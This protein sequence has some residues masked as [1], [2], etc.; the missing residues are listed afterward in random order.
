[1]ADAFA[2]PPVNR[3]VMATGCYLTSIGSLVH[4][5]RVPYPSGRHHQDFYFRWEKGRKLP[6]AT[7]LLISEGK[8]HWESRQQKG[9]LQAGS[10][11]YVAPGTWH[12]YRPSL[13]IGWHEKWLC[14][15]GA[16]VHQHLRHKVLP[17]EVVVLNYDDANEVD[18]RHERLFNEVMAFPQDNLPS[19]GARALSIILEAFENRPAE[20]IVSKEASTFLSWEAEALQFIRHNSHRPITVR[21]VATA[22]GRTRRSVERYFQEQDL[23]TVAQAI[24]AERLVRAKLLLRTTSLSIKEVAAETGFSSTQHLIAT[25]HR[26]EGKTPSQLRMAR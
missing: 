25:C 19:W 21:D 13:Q 15:R 1:M 3:Q 4:P 9:K 5:P 10:L 22:C 8:G 23:G 12:R 18:T 26:L 7:L 14:L 16:F 20:K 24:A 6:D 11:L 2:Y 17:A